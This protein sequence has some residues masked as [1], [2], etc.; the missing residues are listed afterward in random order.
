MSSRNLT[1]AEMIALSAAWLDAHRH[2]PVF[3][4]TPLLAML[5][6]SIEIA[7]QNVVAVT[8]QATAEASA[9]ERELTATQLQAVETDR[10]HDRKGGGALDVLDAALQLTD[11]EGEAEPLR[12]VRARLFP[13]GAQV[14]GQSY[15]AE[16]GNAERVAKELDDPNLC[17]VLAAITVVPGR[18]LLDDVRAFVQAGRDLGALE[19]RKAMLAATVADEGP[20]ND[21]IAASPRADNATARSAW[22]QTTHAVMANAKLLHG[23]DAARLAPMLRELNTVLTKVAARAARRREAAKDASEPEREPAPTTPVVAP[24]ETATPAAPL[25][26]TG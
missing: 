16:A 2:R 13:E 3:L 7:H 19:T 26:R 20:G 23:E 18:T 15:L 10:T 25:A 14:F 11:T 8:P 5:L 1:N 12:K 9:A 4:A 24:T 21:N 6:P 22:S 17:A